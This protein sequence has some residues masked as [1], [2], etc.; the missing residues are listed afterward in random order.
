MDLTSGSA[1][2]AWYDRSPATRADGYSTGAV[3]PH[4]A[5][6]RVSYTVPTGKKALVEL[7]LTSLERDGAPG[8]AG[9]AAALARVTPG[10]G[11]QIAILISR[12]QSATVGAQKVQSLAGSFTLKAGDLLELVTVDG[13]TTGTYQYDLASKVTEF[14]A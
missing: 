11:S 9:A 4:S 14:D 1:R 13:S 6:V 12:D 8:A 2:A 5:T 3:A 7:I 10:T